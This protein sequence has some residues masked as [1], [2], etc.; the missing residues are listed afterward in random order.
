M[1]F[2]VAA[3]A[4]AASDQKSNEQGMQHLTLAYAVRCAAFPAGSMRPCSLHLVDC[5]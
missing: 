1:G 4:A 3:A 2:I 5:M